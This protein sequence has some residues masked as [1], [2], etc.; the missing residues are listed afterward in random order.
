MMLV[1]SLLPNPS[2]DK[3]KLILYRCKKGDRA[4]ASASPTEQ[5]RGVDCSNLGDLF[6]GCHVN[7]CN[8]ISNVRHKSRFVAFAA[9]RDRCKERRI[10]LDK[11]PLERQL[12]DDL[13]LLFGV[14]VGDGSCD[15]NIEI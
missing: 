3:L 5:A 1:S 7:F 6:A 8:F 12:A 10:G 14:F 15:T 9:L 13:T 2:L 11:K 4:Q